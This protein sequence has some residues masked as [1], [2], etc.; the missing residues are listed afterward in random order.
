MILQYASDLHLEFL[1]NKQFLEANPIIPVG[2]I[3][4]L[5]GDIVPFKAIELHRDFFDLVSEQYKFVYWIPGNHEYYHFNINDKQGEFHEAIRKNVFLVNNTW[6]KHDNF[7][8][9][10][11]TLWTN[12]CLENAWRIENSLNDFHHISDGD[13]RFTYL[14]YNSLHQ[15]SMDFILKSTQSEYQE[16]LVVVTHHVPTFINYPM[17]YKNSPLNEAFAVELERFI[18]ES[19]IDFWIY[20]HHHRNVGDFKI[21]NTKLLTNQLGYSHIKEHLS[22]ERDK[23][24]K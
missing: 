21:G 17:E 9:V 15:E 8:I 7:R 22:F 4:I 14:K 3:L 1:E 19:K 12:I 11:S 20:G 2:D 24:V 10:F 13:K 23:I 6:V 16:K 18:K 5:A